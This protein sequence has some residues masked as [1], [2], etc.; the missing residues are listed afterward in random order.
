[1]NDEIRETVEDAPSILIVEDDDALRT[2][3]ERAFADR[4]FHTRA[5]PSG[6][7]AMAAAEADSPELA[8]VDLR[9]PDVDG[10]EVLERLLA[11]DATTRVVILTGYGSIAT[12]IEA[13]RL[14]A[15][16]YVPKPAGVDDILA[17]F[18]RGE[19]EPRLA[20]PR[21]YEAPSLARAEWEHINRVLADCGGNIS[22]TARQLG[23]HR[24]TLQ[25][26]L[27]TYPPS[28]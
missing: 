16:Y 5:A 6:A 14:G 12:A 26:K 10:L 4:G 28:K 15:T 17:A 20:A 13:I 23:L 27:N 21:V 25:R 2:R 3:L 19:S 24:R 7:A 22:R 9:L 11:I 1:M 8:V 18:E